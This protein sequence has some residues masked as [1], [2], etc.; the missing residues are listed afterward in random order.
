M[1]LK[2]LS[3][4]NVPSQISS[5]LPPGHQSA[6]SYDNDTKWD[7]P[8]VTTRHDLDAAHQGRTAVSCTGIPDVPEPHHTAV[9]PT[10]SASEYHGYLWPTLVRYNLDRRV[11]APAAWD[12]RWSILR[13]TH[14][15][16]QPLDCAALL[17]VR[18][19]QALPVG[20]RRDHKISVLVVQS[21]SANRGLVRYSG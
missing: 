6:A 1:N 5:Q 4:T 21:M 15:H 14:W 11:R 3:I 7:L 9:C 10:A 12:M 17:H 18:T 16:D 19:P 8:E 20:F 13:A 2:L